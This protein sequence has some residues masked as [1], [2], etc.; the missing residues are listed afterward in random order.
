MMLHMSPAPVRVNLTGNLRARQVPGQLVNNVSMIIYENI[1][2]ADL[3]QR[4][5][6]VLLTAS[7]R[8]EVGFV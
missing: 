7:G 4:A 3:V 2:D 1:G 6:I 8:I 5:G